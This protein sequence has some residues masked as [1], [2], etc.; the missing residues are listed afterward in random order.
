MKLSAAHETYHTQLLA[1]LSHDFFEE[2]WLREV[3]C[4]RHADED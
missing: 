4:K 1:D 3:V 2:R